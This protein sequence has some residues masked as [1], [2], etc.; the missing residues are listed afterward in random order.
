MKIKVEFDT[1]PEPG[2]VI[3]TAKENGMEYLVDKEGYLI[4]VTTNK[5]VKINTE[6]FLP[7]TKFY[8]ITYKVYIDSIPEEE[9][10]SLEDEKYITVK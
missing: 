1:A 6:D 8:T 2:T 7:G 10:V 3:T 5:V 9:P 4:P